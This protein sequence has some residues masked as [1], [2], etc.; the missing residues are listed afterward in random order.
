MARKRPLPREGALIGKTAL[1]TGASSG[2][3]KAVARRLAE[4]GA[5][6]TLVC[7]DA[8]RGVRAQREIQM[9][10]G[11]GRV[12]LLIADMEDPASIRSMARAFQARHPALQILVNNAGVFAPDLRLTAAGLESTFAINHL[13]YFAVVD[14]LLPALRQGAPARIV[15]VASDAHYRG[16]L[17]WDDPQGVR[18]PYKGWPAYCRSK[19]CNVLYTLELAR[20]L[21]GSGV[22]ANALHP[23]MVATG[24]VRDLPW[25]ARTLWPVVAL[26]AAKAAGFVY[27]LAESPALAGVSG[28]YFEKLREKAPAAFAL[29]P[30]NGRRLWEL[31]EQLLAQSAERAADAG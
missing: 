1:V 7:R 26:S 27:H 28:K 25:I 10:T 13:G 11:S 31:S 16:R 3:G 2:I 19:L 21:E 4:A 30:E 22:S 12:E 17:D 14:A 23:G 6:V 8:E 24:I 5:H 29:M 9:Q 20:R 15:N 18:E